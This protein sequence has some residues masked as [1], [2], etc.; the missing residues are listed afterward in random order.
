MTETNKD[1]NFTT[2]YVMKKPLELWQAFVTGVLLIGSVTGAFVNLTNKIQTQQ[3][4]LEYLESERQDYKNQ[5]KEINSKLTEILIEVH[6]KEDR[7][8]K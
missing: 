6:N 1:S 8:L 5:F 4:R 2:Q 3:I 7:P